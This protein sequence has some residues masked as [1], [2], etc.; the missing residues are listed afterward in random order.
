MY[1]TI[2]IDR[3]NLTI[4]GKPFP[5]LDTPGNTANAIGSNMFE[6]LEATEKRKRIS[7]K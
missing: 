3:T 5:D 2:K 6:R 4:M 1:K 7:E